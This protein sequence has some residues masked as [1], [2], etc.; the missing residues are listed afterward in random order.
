MS[1]VYRPKN[2]HRVARSNWSYDHGGFD[3]NVHGGFV[4]GALH[5]TAGAALESL[6][7]LNVADEHYPR[8]VPW[9]ASASEA[10][11]MARKLDRVLHFIDDND[12]QRDYAVAWR[13][14]LATCSGYWTFT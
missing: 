1:V 3:M 10:R 7:N 2:K 13:D 11:A 12:S 5:R 9:R 8:R 6:S 4:L 14:F